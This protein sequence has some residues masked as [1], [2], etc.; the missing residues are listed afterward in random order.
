MCKKTSVKTRVHGVTRKK[1]ES[2]V[3]RNF[4][5]VGLD[6]VSRVKE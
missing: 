4:E 2:V 5:K 6:F 3:G 1:E